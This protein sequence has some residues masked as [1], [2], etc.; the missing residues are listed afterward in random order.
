MG[1]VRCIALDW[2]GAIDYPNQLNHIWIAEACHNAII[3]M[4]NGLTRT[5]AIDYL[6]Q[7]VMPGKPAVIGLDFAFG[8]PQWCQ[9]H[10]KY[11]G[12][13]KLWALA[14]RQGERWFDGNSWPLWGRKGRY[15]KRPQD[16]WPTLRYRQTDRDHAQFKPKSVFKLI[17][18]G[19]VGTGTIRGLTHLAR[20]HQAGAAIWPFS[21][22]NPSGVSVIEIYPRLFYGTLLTNNT[23]VEGRDHRRDF[24]GLRYR[25]LE[26]HWRDIMIGSADAFDAGVSALVMSQY[27]ADFM[28]SSEGTPRTISGRGQDL[29]TAGP[30]ASRHGHLPASAATGLLTQCMNRRIYRQNF[31]RELLCQA[32]L[33]PSCGPADEASS[34]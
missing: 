22:V 4:R 5:E 17:G 15:L 12:V 30:P 8:Y 32:G 10:F 3:R 33:I 28:P 16:L 34:S 24:L 26:R 2:S 21:D 23:S 7:E 14:G 29:D 6:I 27:A 31:R 13:Q 20:L 11:N 9:Y 19:Q 18:D 1:N 25:H